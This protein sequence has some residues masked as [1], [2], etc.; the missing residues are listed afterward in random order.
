MG[1][2]PARMLLPAWS[3]WYGRSK[4]MPK[5]RD[6]LWR[7]WVTALLHSFTPCLIGQSG[8]GRKGKRGRVKGVRTREWREQRKNK[9]RVKGHMPLFGLNLHWGEQRRKSGE[10]ATTACKR[11]ERVQTWLL[12]WCKIYHLQLCLKQSLLYS[13]L[14]QDCRRGNL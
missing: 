9:A 13:L 3:S 14:K 2:T 12:A 8:A 6:D 10:D 1:M 4:K 11:G 5:S 7:S